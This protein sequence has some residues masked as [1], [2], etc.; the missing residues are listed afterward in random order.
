MLKQVLM[1]L[2]IALTIII[3]I[4]SV[5]NGQDKKSLVVLDFKPVNLSPSTVAEFSDK[6][7]STLRMIP[8][9][10]ILDRD[11]VE[12][13][14]DQG[15]FQSSQCISISCLKKL[16][17][18]AGVE[19]VVGGTIIHTG[20]T[21]SVGMRIFNAEAGKVISADVIYVKADDGVLL[22]EGLSAVVIKVAGSSASI[23]KAA[24]SIP[25][26]SPKESCKST[27]EILGWVLKSRIKRV[28][29]YYVEYFPEVDELY[30]ILKANRYRARKVDLNTTGLS[31]K[32]N[33]LRIGRWKGIFEKPHQ[34][35]VLNRYY[36]LEWGAVFIGRKEYR[37]AIFSSFSEDDLPYFVWVDKEL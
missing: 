10:D 7:R 6:V 31:V 9:F 30:N 11:S 16:A 26:L 20:S 18:L 32:E 14:L 13:I 27:R 5:L 25:E 34:F 1:I 36:P 33:I 19:Q 23:P 8:T 24:S 28:T 29:I 17:E 12:K 21:Y 4:S 35:V 2:G 22:D 15:G 37:E 3:H